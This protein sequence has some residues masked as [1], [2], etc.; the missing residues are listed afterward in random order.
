MLPVLGLDGSPRKGD[1]GLPRVCPHT[2]PSQETEGCWEGRAKFALGSAEGGWRHPVPVTEAGIAL[3]PWGLVPCNA[4]QLPCLSRPK[5]LPRL[6]GKLC[7]RQSCPLPPSRSP[8]PG[9][10]APDSVHSGSPQ[11]VACVQFLSLS[12]APEARPCLAGQAFIV[13][14]AEQ[15]SAAWEGQQSLP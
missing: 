4:V 8:F 6:E 7:P 1:P 11:G 2:S 3:I 9:S 13:F 14:R 5:A 10:P 12:S 15:Q